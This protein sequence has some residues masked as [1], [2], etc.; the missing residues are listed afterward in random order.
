MKSN[1]IVWNLIVYENKM[2]YLMDRTKSAYSM[3]VWVPVAYAKQ[4]CEMKP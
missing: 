2:K 1:L 4:I 3:Q